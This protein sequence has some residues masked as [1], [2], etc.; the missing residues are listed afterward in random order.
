MHRKSLSDLIHT[1]CLD[2]GPAT[3]EEAVQDAHKQISAIMEIPVEEAE[4][5]L[6]TGMR[7]Y[8]NIKRRNRALWTG[9]VAAGVAVLAWRMC[10]ILFW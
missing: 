9:L 2:K 3:D 1:V 5:I 7:D 10:W 4:G 6:E 8:D